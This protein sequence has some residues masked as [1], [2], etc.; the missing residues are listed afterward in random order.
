MYSG[1]IRT[2]N[3]CIR[4]DG[5]RID[6][7]V[8]P[9]SSR[10][11]KAWRKKPGRFIMGVMEWHVA[12]LLAQSCCHDPRYGSPVCSPSGPCYAP[13]SRGGTAIQGSGLPQ[14]E[15]YVCVRVHIAVDL[16]GVSSSI[17]TAPAVGDTCK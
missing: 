11:N 14:P 2:C 4:I 17:I 5:I 7:T 8:H 9:P 6:C 12:P 10:R 13:S 3:K 16:E 15:E 1:L